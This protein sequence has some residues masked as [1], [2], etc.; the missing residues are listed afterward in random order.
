MNDPEDNRAHKTEAVEVPFRDLSV[1]ALRGV[2]ESYVLREGTDYGTVE[3]TLEEKIAAVQ[4]QLEAGTAVILYD[5]E[6]RSIDLVRREARGR[7]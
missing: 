7:K 4:A 6:T 2:V 5:P 3:C 1:A